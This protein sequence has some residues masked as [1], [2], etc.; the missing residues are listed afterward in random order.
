EGDAEVNPGGSPVR[1]EPGGLLEF[2]DRIA[3]P[4]LLH[5]ADTAGVG[6][7]GGDKIGVRSGFRTEIEPRRDTDPYEQHDH[8]RD[9]PCAWTTR[10]GSRTGHGV[11]GD[12]RDGIGDGTSSSIRAR[13][14]PGEEYTRHSPSD[15][16]KLAARRPLS[17]ARAP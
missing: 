15:S 10:R 11:P 17:P 4:K 8:E 16:S 2:L 14:G 3:V 7:R 13:T 12:G 9:D 6:M 1:G 5:E